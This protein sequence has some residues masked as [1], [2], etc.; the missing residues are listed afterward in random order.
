MLPEL[1]EAAF[2]NRRR[3]G[4]FFAGAAERARNVLD[5]SW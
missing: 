3:L 4:A 5:Q 1:D 2:E